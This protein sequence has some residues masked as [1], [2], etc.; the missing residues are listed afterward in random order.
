M[1]RP[2]GPTQGCVLEEVREG[3]KNAHLVR[4]KCS[5][6]FVTLAEKSEVNTTTTTTRTT[7]NNSRVCYDMITGSSA[8]IMYRLVNLPRPCNSPARC[9]SRQTRRRARCPW[10]HPP[11]CARAHRG[12]ISAP[13]ET[14]AK[15]RGG[16]QR[17]KERRS[18]FF[19]L[20][21]LGYSDLISEARKEAVPPV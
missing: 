16:G 14:S 13:T 9:P 20:S 8:R 4:S 15:E 5:E 11:S 2:R 18:F 3:V 19:F 21:G 17:R 6:R 7:A 10:L 12:T 1:N